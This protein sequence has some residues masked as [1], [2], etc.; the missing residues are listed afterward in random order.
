MEE[1]LGIIE[2]FKNQRIL[3]VGDL[4][5]DQ[6]FCGE[7]NRI[8]SEA[9]VPV[10]DVKK[11]N[12]ILG[13][14][15]NAANNLKVL[16]AKAILA[17][18]IGPDDKGNM[19]KEMLGQ[20]GIDAQGVVVDEKRKTTVK[21]RTMAKDQQLL[22]IGMEDRAFI[23]TKTEDKLFDIIKEKI[24]DVNALIISDYERGVFTPSLTR[25]IIE[26]AGQNKVII[27]A[28]AK[29]DDYLKYKGCNVITLNEKELSRAFTFQIINEEQLAFSGKRLLSDLS[30]GC[31]LVK[32]GGKGMTLFE[33]NGEKFHYP[34]VNQEVRD[35]SGAGDTALVAFALSLGAGVDFKKSVII[36]SY[37]CGIAV[38]KIG[39]A[40]VLPEELKESLKGVI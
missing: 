12:Y 3:V 24:K 17:G 5:L 35:V 10:L 1:I 16:G 37:A 13:G 26:L 25:R 14:A 8:S 4:I 6:Y 7:V 32:Q 22:C 33:K 21:I 18:V 38:G 30:S 23:D 19:L 11:I 20:A 34:A 27:F 31:V 39:T 15:A 40:V 2:S 9:P 28:D 36:A 29:G